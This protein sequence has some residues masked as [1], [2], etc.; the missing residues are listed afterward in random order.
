MQTGGGSVGAGQWAGWRRW[1]CRARAGGGRLTGA[2]GEAVQD[3]GRVCI[4]DMHG[5]RGGRRGGDG[6][7]GTVVVRCQG[8]GVAGGTRIWGARMGGSW[9]RGGGGCRTRGL[10]G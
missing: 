3:R 1:G 5:G 4:R 9:R 2:V 6:G 8:A 10:G 7:R